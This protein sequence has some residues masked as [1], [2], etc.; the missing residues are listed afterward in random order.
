[1]NLDRKD[2]LREIDGLFGFDAGTLT[3]TELLADTGH[4]DSMTVLEFIA[5]A[6]ERYQVPLSPWQFRR[7][8]TVDDLFRVCERAARG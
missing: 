5:L 6:D 8:A 4:W 1:M 2:F 7:C 3:G